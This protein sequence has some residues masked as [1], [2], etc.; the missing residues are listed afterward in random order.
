MT[1]SYSNGVS[2]NDRRALARLARP[3]QP[4]QPQPLLIA[5]VGTRAFAIPVPSVERILRMAEITPMP[6]SSPALVGVVNYRGSVI[7]VLDP[8]F[9]LGVPAAQPSP[10]QY[11]VLLADDSR[12]FLWVDD[13]ESLVWFDAAD[14]GGTQVLALAP[15]A[16]PV[17]RLE[18]RVLPILAPSQWDARTGLLQAPMLA[19]RVGTWQ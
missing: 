1:T 6:G 16:T 3:A 2:H 4:E 17:A 14:S 13:V 9:S 5:Q 18:G 12:F 11:L 8:R 19:E 10:E 15:G 7:P